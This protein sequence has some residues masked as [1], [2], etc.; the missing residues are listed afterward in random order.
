[1]ASG[2]LALLRGGVLRR[3]HHRRFHH[4]RHATGRFH[5]C[6]P[7]C[8]NSSRQRS[9]MGRLGTHSAYSRKR[10]S[11]TRSVQGS[12]PRH[13]GRFWS[14]GASRPCVEPSHLTRAKPRAERTAPEE[15]PELAPDRAGEP[16][17]IGAVGDLAQEGCQVRA[18]RRDGGGCPPWPGA[19]R[20]RPARSL[21]QRGVC[22]PRIGAKEGVPALDGP[23]RATRIRNTALR[24]ESDRCRQIRAGTRFGR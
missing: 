18:G 12:I 24:A 16:A 15:L 11:R 3:F 9:Y 20:W 17:T 10:R 14:G 8:W 19:D 5:Q 2:E 23:A 6:S 13:R 21:R 1:M 22:R 7:T 4:V